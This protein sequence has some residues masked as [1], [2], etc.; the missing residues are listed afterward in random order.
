MNRSSKTQLGSRLGA[1][2]S[3]VDIAPA[4]S[5]YC[6]NQFFLSKAA[7]CTQ[8]FEYWQALYLK[9][10][11]TSVCSLGP[12]RSDL[13]IQHHKAEAGLKDVTNQPELTQMNAKSTSAGWYCRMLYAIA[14]SRA[15]A[16]PEPYVCYCYGND[17]YL[18]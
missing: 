15:P 1:G 6:C 7:A 2:G 17:T 5:F 16:C 18:L 12:L 11:E 9:L 4:S 3:A 14:F 8:S 10:S 13:Y